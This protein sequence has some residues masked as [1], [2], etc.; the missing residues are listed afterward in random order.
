MHLPS[1]PCAKAHGFLFALSSPPHSKKAAQYAALR[2]KLL[3]NLE[4]VFCAD[5]ES[6]L[7]SYHLLVKGTGF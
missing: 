2:V 7:Y 4:S 1:L 5:D 3:F 6:N